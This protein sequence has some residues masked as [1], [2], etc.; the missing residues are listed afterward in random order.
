MEDVD[1]GLHPAVDGLGERWKANT[2]QKPTMDYFEINGSGFN[3]AHETFEF[4]HE[5]LPVC[6]T[7]TEDWPSINKTNTNSGCY[8]KIMETVF[9]NFFYVDNL[10]ITSAEQ[11]KW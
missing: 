7:Q 5:S 3:Q 6:I 4:A 2:G 9:F 1:G 8:T 11:Y 10:H